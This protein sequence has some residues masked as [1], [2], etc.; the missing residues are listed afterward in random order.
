MSAILFTVKADMQQVRIQSTVVEQIHILICH[1]SNRMQFIYIQRS[2]LFWGE[3][4][5]EQYSVHGFES[6]YMFKLKC[7]KCNIQGVRKVLSEFYSYFLTF[8]FR[9]R[10]KILL[11]THTVQL[12]YYI[13]ETQL[14]MRKVA[15][16]NAV[17]QIMIISKL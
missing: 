13:K 11:Y 14:Q 3:S 2:I 8:D 15:I 1:L 4:E 6:P 12:I 16:Q 9:T 7:M 5:D 10:R 17:N